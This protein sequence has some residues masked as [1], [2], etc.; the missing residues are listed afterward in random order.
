MP[1][2]KPTQW[3]QYTELVVLFYLQSMAVAMWMV[4]L[5]IVLET[6]GLHQIIPYA[7]AT[8]AAAAF[9]SPLVFGAM[10]DRHVSPVKVLRWLSVAAAITMAAVA[11][12]IHKGLSPGWVLL[13]IQLQALCF[14][15]TGSITTAIVFAGLRNSQQEFGPVRA[16]AT[17]GWMCGCWVISALN[18][19]ASVLAMYSDAVVWLMLAAFTFLLPS[20]APPK[21]TE[22]LTLRQRMG[23]DALTLLKKHDHRVV[24]ITAAL[25]YIPL[26]AFYPFTPPQL[27]DLGLIHT[28]AWMTLGQC[29][30]MVAMFS[31]AALLARFRLK[32]VF[33]TGL[34]FGV[35]RFALC[36]MNGKAWVLAGVSLH[37]LS[38]VLF[39]ITA[40]I[41]VNERV[42]AAWRVRAQALLAL[43]INGAGSLLGYLGNGWWFNACTQ[44]T[45]TSWPRFW[46][47]ISASVAVVLVYFLIA[48]HGKYSG[49]MRRPED[50]SAEMAT[51]PL[52]RIP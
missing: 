36:A 1:V 52:R 51:L 50:G 23:W 46:G 9:V 17:F 35:L 48:Y 5:S 27:R 14:T 4:P 29:S 34:I 24:F 13:L 3:A 42:D 28:S 49:M 25:F 26:I 30:E 33:A 45:G 41:Y 38:L 19:D 44:S 39:L 2:R 31:L 20:I 11:L 10:A 21:S 22:R 6:H 32:W 7:F 16:G 47:G 15:P 37:G 12:A 40:Q 8:T 43:M 18:A